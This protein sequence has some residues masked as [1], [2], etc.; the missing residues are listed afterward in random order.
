M[1]VICICAGFGYAWSVLQNPIVEY[2][3][4]KESAV[5]LTY[6]IT[7]VCSSLTPLAFGNVIGKMR[8]R[9]CVLVGCILFG[10]GIFLCG[11]MT[12]IWQLYLFY[13]V[14]SGAGCGMIYPRMM[15]YA[16]RLYP[17][18]TGMASGLGTAA[19]G[20]GAVLWAPVAAHLIDSGSLAGAFRLLG[21]VFLA[22]I[23]AGTVFLADPPEDWGRDMRTETQDPD[24]EKTGC[25]GRNLNRSEMVRTKEFR[26][27]LI[28]FT[29]GLIA[30][31]IVISQA[32][33]ILQEI[34]AFSPARAAVF[35]GVFSFCNMGGRFLWGSISDRIGIRDTI[36]VVAVITAVS[37]ILLPFAKTEVFVIL[38]MAVSA[39]CY[40]G[41]ASLLTPLTAELFGP[42]Y[43]TANYG[44][45]Y[46]VFG[47]ASMIGPML[48]VRFQAAGS[49]NGAFLT[50]AVLACLGFVLS[51]KF[52]RE[53]RH[54]G[55]AIS[56]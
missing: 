48:A 2:F 25:A 10:C 47:I 53:D 21:L 40:G 30:G 33:P 56:E 29:C 7:V 36:R 12:H 3:G 16:V 24:K 28:V 11:I 6:T 50:A 41:F 45:M 8:T 4:W 35:V 54:D 39:S 38:L 51:G 37:M 17:D 32:S 1:L 27:A 55:K 18:R 44:V 23:L 14:L 43:I 22:V 31:V 49:Y 26:I 46:V 13:G 9:T 15:A 5:S 34:L 42:R 19:Y 52:P 20:S